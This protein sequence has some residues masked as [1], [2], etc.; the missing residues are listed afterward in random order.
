MHIY[1]KIY[2]FAASAGAFEGY[3]Y[4]KKEI[5]TNYLPEWVGH[6]VV[7]YEHLSP[8]VSKEIQSSLDGTL[9]R[10]LRALIPILD[11]EDETIRKLKSMIG[12]DLPESADDFRKEK[13]FEKQ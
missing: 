3:V 2:E 7:A 4:P 11:E 9:G 13:W 10:A 5:Y 1:T 12:G 8:E 6:L